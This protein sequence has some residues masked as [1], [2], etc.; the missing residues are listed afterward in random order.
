[1]NLIDEFLNDP[2][3]ED[4]NFQKSLFLVYSKIVPRYVYKFCTI[5]ENLLT[6][7]ENN[8]L[9]FS[10]SDGFNDP[11]DCDINISNDMSLNEI[12]IFVNKFIEHNY[13]PIEFKSKFI[14]LLRENPQKALNPLDERIRKQ[15]KKIGICCFSKEKEN[16]LMWANYADKHRGVCLKFDV[17]KDTDFFFP[18]GSKPIGII[19]NVEYKE[20]Y[21][22]INP[23]DAIIEKS[24]IKNLP[25]TKSS[26]WFYEKEFRVIASDIENVPLGIKF[27]KDSLLEINLGCQINN[28][29][30]P[31]ITKQDLFEI[32]K[33]VNYPNLKFFQVHKSNNKFELKFEKYL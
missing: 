23:Y 5:D 9:W 28:L 4:V 11:F 32:V 24:V 15:L 14:A 2:R 19:R 20:K 8:Q 17:L 16:I 27:N 6:N 1:M 18:G 33:K 25:F 21:P 31:K 13:I 12:E 22:K 29:E 10:S 7:L 3:L 30:K 26:D